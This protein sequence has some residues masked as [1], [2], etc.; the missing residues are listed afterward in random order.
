MKKGKSARFFD[1]ELHDGNTE[2][3]LI[4]FQD[5]QRKRLADFQS[6]SQAVSINN[7]TIKRARKSD[8]LEVILK[9][10]SSN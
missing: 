8:D 1:A 9:S 3:R 7:C 10:N 2:M 5:S 6:S 4:G